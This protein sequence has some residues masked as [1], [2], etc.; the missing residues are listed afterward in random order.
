MDQSVSEETDGLSMASA[1]ASALAGR[2]L[3]MRVGSP[4]GDR[5][6]AGHAHCAQA[7]R[8][9]TYWLASLEIMGA[10]VGGTMPATRHTAADAT[11]PHRQGHGP[12]ET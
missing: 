10:V 3:V 11:K 1:A 6:R 2:D 9:D 5:R 7:V 12:L 4:F 8:T